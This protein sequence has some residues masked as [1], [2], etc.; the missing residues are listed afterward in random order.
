[1]VVYRAKGLLAG[2][3]GCLPYNIF[4]DSILWL[5]TVQ[6]LCGQYCVV[7]YRGK[8]LLTVLCGCLPCNGFVDS[9]AWLF[10]Y[11]VVGYM[12]PVDLS[13][14]CTLVHTNTLIHSGSLWTVV[15]GVVITVQ[16]LFVE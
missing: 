14:G 16:R 1:M 9:I 10:V 7:V 2:L 11:S 3:C 15:Y 4:V 6:R 8:G 5:F 13:D 12:L